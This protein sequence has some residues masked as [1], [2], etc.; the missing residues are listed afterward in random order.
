VSGFPGG[1]D[2]AGTAAIVSVCDARERTLPERAKKQACREGTVISQ[3]ELPDP[4][5]S[6]GPSGPFGSESS[7]SEHLLLQFY[8]APRSTKRVSLFWNIASPRM[9]WKLQIRRNFLRRTTESPYARPL[10]SAR[11]LRWIT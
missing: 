2:D 4:F 3:F 8:S 11:L 9:L 10:Q 7:F 1:A 5:G 6:L